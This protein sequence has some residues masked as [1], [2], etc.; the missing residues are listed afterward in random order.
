MNPRLQAGVE[1]QLEKQAN[2]EKELKNGYGTSGDGDGRLPPPVPGEKK[3]PTEDTGR[4][5]WLHNPKKRSLA[6]RSTDARWEAEHGRGRYHK[7]EDIMANMWRP[8]PPNKKALELLR[9]K[10]AEQRRA[11]AE[12]Y[13]QPK[14]R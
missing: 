11:K 2:E 7:L 8:P 13:A 14:Q 9:K 4:H 6:Q 12:A 5:H 1:L 10:I 3:D